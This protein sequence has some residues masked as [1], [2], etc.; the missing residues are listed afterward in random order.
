VH[1]WEGEPCLPPPLAPF[2]QQM[3]L[4]CPQCTTRYQADAAKFQPSGRNVRCAKCSHLWHQDAPSSEADAASD[5]AVV[6]DTPPPPPPEP[7][8][9]RAAAFAPNP[10]V[11][12]DTV[13]MVTPPEKVSRLPT[14][15][16]AGAGWAGLIVLILLVG[17][18]AMTF[19]QQIATVW[20]QSASLY[21]ALGVKTNAT[22]IDIKDVSFQRGGQDG[23]NVLV[24]SGM[25]DNETSRELPVPQIRVALIDDDRH[26][27]YHWTFVPG[28]MTLKAG[29]TSKFSTRLTDPP[30]GA[31]RF[32]L[33]F[34]KAG[35]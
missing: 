9:P 25:L 4:T 26:E 32:E 8:A 11:S 15:L 29:Q 19:R 12:R 10:V 24:V 22:G 20:P 13:R 14:Q 27:L 16:A 28:V 34:A 3:I 6:D 30:A 2:S 31:R 7:M 1:W 17:W 23:R 33:R 5:I 35:E 18:T 21:A